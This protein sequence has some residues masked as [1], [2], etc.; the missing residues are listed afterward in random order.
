[1]QIHVDLTLHDERDAA[2]LRDI[3]TSLATLV[4]GDKRIMGKLEELRTELASANE[5]TNEIASDVEELVRKA[6]EGGLTPEDLAAA[7]ALT[8][9]L[10]AVAAAYTADAP[11]A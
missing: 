2:I 10:R 7:T 9:R 5:V 11:P 6:T 1:M 3:Q 8:G 4:R